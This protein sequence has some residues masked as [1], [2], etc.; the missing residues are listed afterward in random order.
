M[1]LQQ[2]EYRLWDAVQRIEA[3]YGEVVSVRNKRKT[4]L[5]FGDNENVGTARTTVM[6][7]PIGITNE[8]YISTNEIDTISSADAGDDQLVIVEG[9]T[10]SN[11]E[12]T[13]KIQNAIL[14]G[15]NKV[16]LDTP[17]ARCTRVYNADSTDLTGPVYVY[18]DTA[19]TSGVPNDGTKVHLIVPS[20]DN[21]SKKASTTIS[22]NDYWIITN[23]YAS[24]LEKS[25]AFADVQLEFRQNG[26]VFRPFFDISISSNSGTI[27]LD[28][29]PC[30]IVPSN[31][32]VRMTA[33]AGAANIHVTA[34]INGYLA[35]AGGVM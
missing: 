20:G 33:L 9:H 13:F 15:Q 31:S 6:T 11:G 18:Q 16:T 28:L 17:L 12:F 22:K 5:K 30:I 3:D 23:I 14:N 21:Q 2:L 26:F 4:L 10:L 35:S 32:D 1:A 8:T 29:D 27:Q 19:I 34:G 7:L 24:V 25:S